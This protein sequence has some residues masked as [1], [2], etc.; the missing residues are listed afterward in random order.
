MAGEKPSEQTV[1][2]SREY[3]LYA[4]RLENSNDKFDS[5]ALDKMAKDK[6]ISI[7]T[8]QAIKANIANGTIKLPEVTVKKGIIRNPFKPKEKTTK[9][10][11]K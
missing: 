9:K 11:K 7:I 6:Q 2:L 3:D 1:Q 10:K 5:A 8:Y 4:N